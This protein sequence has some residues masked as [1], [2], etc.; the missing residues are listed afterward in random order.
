MPVQTHALIIGGGIAR[1][2][3]GSAPR[4]SRNALRLAKGLRD[5]AGDITSAFA[6]LERDRR[7]RAERIIAYGRRSGDRPCP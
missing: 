6:A 2:R 5:R 1:P 3:P 7:R 4:S